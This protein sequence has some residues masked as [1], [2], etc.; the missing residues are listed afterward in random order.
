MYGL[1]YLSQFLLLT[2]VMWKKYCLFVTYW[3]SFQ[4]CFLYN[5]AIGLRVSLF[6]LVWRKPIVRDISGRFA[7]CFWLKNI[8]LNTVKYT[9]NTLKVKFVTSVSFTHTWNILVVCACV[10][11]NLAYLREFSNR[12]MQEQLPS[13][14]LLLH[15]L[16]PVQRSTSLNYCGMF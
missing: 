12:G 5:I 8:T 16:L 4:S 15:F 11:L 1:V 9:I 3:G 13:G 7:T 6:I 14:L 10:C 2:A